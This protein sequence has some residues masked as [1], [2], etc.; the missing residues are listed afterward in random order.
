MNGQVSRKGARKVSLLRG[1][2][3]VV[4]GDRWPVPPAVQ[5][6][7]AFLALQERP[8]PRREVASRLWPD[9]EDRRCAANLR[10]A[11]WRIRQPDAQ[12][13]VADDGDLS[14]SP[15]VS[16]DVRSMTVLAN[17]LL[18]SADPCEDVCLSH[19]TLSGD[20]LPGW[21]EDWVLLERERIRQL[22]LH[23]FDA[24]AER[25]IELGRYG[26]AVQVSMKSVQEEPLRE[27]PH[28]LLVSVHLAEGNVSEA[29]REF[30]RYRDLLTV[31]LGVEPS[32][33][34]CALVEGV[35]RTRAAKLKPAARTG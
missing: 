23:A 15:D 1:F 21:Y 11:L 24:L 12:L 26:Q 8:T 20:L 6:V 17:R 16:V 19:E 14:I 2:E 25:L 27:T 7:M 28:R 34:M 22:R 33:M 30:D 4:D 13:V 35:P 10:S 32:E 9:V 29:V 18:D 5:R 31:E 3:L